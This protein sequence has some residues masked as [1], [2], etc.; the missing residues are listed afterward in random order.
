MGLVLG[1]LAI[2]IFTLV[3][4]DSQKMAITAYVFY[5]EEAFLLIGSL[6]LGGICSLIPSFQ[7]YRTDI[8]KVLAGN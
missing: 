2:L 7:A 4:E 1:H 6:V 8:H 3:L 5:P